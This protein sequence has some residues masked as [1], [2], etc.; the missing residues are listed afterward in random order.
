MWTWSRRN[1][2]TSDVLRTT[3][4]GSLYVGVFASATDQ[5]S[6]VGLPT[7]ASTVAALE[8]ELGVP[9]V[10]CSI[11]GANTLGALAVGNETG[12]LVSDRLTDDERAT[13]EEAVKSPIRTLPGRINAA[14]NCLLVNDYGAI[15]HPDLPDH[16]IDV[17]RDALEVSVERL[18]IGGMRTVGTAAV[19]TN[20]GVLCHPKVTDDE[21]DTLEEVLDVRADVGTVNYGSPLIGSGLVANRQGFVAGEQTTGPELGRIEEALGFLG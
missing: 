1:T 14:G 18:R 17:V 7:D 21:L 13:I 9:V 6:L 16:A 19:A 5:V 4:Q 8:D 2:Q 15:A 10:R 3:I 11:G 12:L 20:H